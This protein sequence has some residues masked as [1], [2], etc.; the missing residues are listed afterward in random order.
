MS[1][2]IEHE[3][4]WK[5]IC[6]NNFPR[7]TESSW[8]DFD[9]PSEG[10]RRRGDIMV[11]CLTYVMLTL[12]SLRRENHFIAP[13]YVSWQYL[14]YLPLY[15]LPSR[16]NARVWLFDP[17]HELGLSFRN[18]FLHIS[19]FLFKSLESSIDVCHS[20]FRTAVYSENKNADPQ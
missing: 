20:S 3:H 1:A 11:L 17:H 4:T 14:H 8:K 18:L 15:S 6:W 7:K 5:W 10:R 13:C 19:R 16:E 9:C 12:P 2:S